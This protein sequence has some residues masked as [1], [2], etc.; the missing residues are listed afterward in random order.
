[1]QC[2]WNIECSTLTYRQLHIAKSYFY[3]HDKMH[4]E[5]NL[6]IQK[7]SIPNARHSNC[8]KCLNSDLSSDKTF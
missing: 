8:S 5:S 2:Y 6:M 1:M 3:L 4:H 7:G